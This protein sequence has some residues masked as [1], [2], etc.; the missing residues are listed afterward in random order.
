[1]VASKSKLLGVYPDTNEPSDKIK[2][3][4]RTRLAI[5]SINAWRWDEAITTCFFPPLRAQSNV[6]LTGLEGAGRDPVEEAWCVEAQHAFH[7]TTNGSFVPLHQARFSN[8]CRTWLFGVVHPSILCMFVSMC[9]GGDTVNHN[10][11]AWL[12][13]RQGLLRDCIEL[14]RIAKHPQQCFLATVIAPDTP[15]EQFRQTEQGV[16]T[17]VAWPGAD[18]FV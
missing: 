15:I 2:W 12:F 6:A 3:T 4:A 7:S 17:K 8:D 5:P 1:M 10:E 9:L 13:R 11:S 16:A 14:F 18:L